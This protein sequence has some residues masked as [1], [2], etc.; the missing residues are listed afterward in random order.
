MGFEEI[1]VS[2]V[3]A[4]ALML[5]AVHVV[6]SSANFYVSDYSAVCLYWGSEYMGDI[7]VGEHQP[8]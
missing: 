7:C 1:V 3:F 8:R 6:N 5:L 2:L 4:I